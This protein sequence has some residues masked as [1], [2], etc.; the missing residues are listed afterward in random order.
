[1]KGNN[2]PRIS[3]GLPVYNGETYLCK[4]LDS[5]LAQTYSDFEL[6]ISDNASND[7]TREICLDYVSKD[8]RIKYLRNHENLGAAKNYNLLVDVAHGEYFKWQAADDVCDSQFLQHCIQI[9]DQD[10]E[11]VLCYPRTRIIDENGA[12]LELYPDELHLIQPNA[13]QRYIQFHQRFRKLEKCN[14]VFGLIRIEALRKTRLIDRF[15]SSDMILLAELALLG[16]L[17]EL[18]EY[19]FFRRDHP[20]TSMRAYSKDERRTWFDPKN[21]NKY[22]NFYW[23]I[24]AEYLRS[25]HEVPAG[26]SAPEKLLCY[27]EVIRWGVWRR[28]LL[29]SELLS[30]AVRRMRRLPKPIKGPLYWAW[31]RSRALASSFSG[32]PTTHPKGHH[33]EDE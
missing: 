1:M 3:I 9:L 32:S 12:L 7:R 28:G 18:P 2:S 6:I 25:I 5:L 17:Y 30:G 29:S 24:F 31:N 21:Q 26:L 15:R 20:Q 23:T 8:S 4:S 22:Q 19:L 33:Q 14:S 27:W 11:V 13:L 10:R 16:K